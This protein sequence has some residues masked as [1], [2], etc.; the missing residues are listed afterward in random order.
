MLFNRRS[1]ELGKIGGSFCP[2]KLKQGQ[3]ALAVKKC[4]FFQ[5]VLKYS[6]SVLLGLSGNFYSL[7]FSSCQNM[8]N[9]GNTPLLKTFLSIKLFFRAYKNINKC[10][11]L[12]T[13]M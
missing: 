2:Q 7:M 4:F 12:L 1:L 5:G 3:H 10:T 11:L 13:T 8:S 9:T 6:L